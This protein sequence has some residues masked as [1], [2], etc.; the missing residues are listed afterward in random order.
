M[1]IEK[2]AKT[3]NR[4]CTEEIHIKYMKTSTSLIRNEM[5]IKQ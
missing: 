5:Q 3:M 4:K 2:W 1:L